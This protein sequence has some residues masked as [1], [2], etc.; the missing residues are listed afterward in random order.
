VGDEIVRRLNENNFAV[1][2]RNLEFDEKQYEEFKQI[3][4]DLGAYWSERIM[5][6]KK[7]VWMIFEI[8]QMLM[9]SA[10]SSETV[11]PQKS[12]LIWEIALE[13]DSLITE[14]FYDESFQEMG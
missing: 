5:I 7:I 10:R 13:I 4:N 8:P 3:I 9:N 11:S 12:A 2:M 14:L 6:E 1:M